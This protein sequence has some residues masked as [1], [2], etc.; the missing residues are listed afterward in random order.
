MAQ[1]GTTGVRELKLANREAPGRPLT[2]TRNGDGTATL[3]LG[4]MGITDVTIT[5]TEEE[6]ASVAAVLA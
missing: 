1:A 2:V 3:R 5:L 6:A 4:D